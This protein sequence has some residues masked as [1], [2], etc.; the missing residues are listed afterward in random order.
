MDNEKIEQELQAGE[1]Q[2][3]QPEGSSGAEQPADDA[4]LEEIQVLRT[5][6]AEL[7]IKLALLTGGAAPE[8]LDEGVKLAAG[9]MEADGTEPDDAAAEVLREYP[10][11]RLVK[12]SVPQF[13][14]ESRGS[15]DGFAA[16]R[17]I[18]ARK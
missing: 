8:K 17:S 1:I 9:L 15:S 2:Q 18:F 3:E 14:A 5:E 10:H 16:I 7:R 12:R 4:R 13:S 11:I 6:V